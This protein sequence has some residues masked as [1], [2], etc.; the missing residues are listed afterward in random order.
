MPERARGV[1][2]GASA[3]TPF[4][5]RSA[6]GGT[7]ASCVRGGRE[8]ALCPGCGCAERHRL[9]WLWL[10]EEDRLIGRVLAFGPDDAS[11]ERLRRRPGLEYVSADV[12]ASQA[13]VVADIV[14]LPFA[15]A[16]FDAVLCS[17]VLEHVPGEQRALAELRRVVRPGGG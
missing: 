4:S 5:A 7:G 16:S 2:G 10:A 8:G 6:T 9:L 3:A 13:M 14:A 11:E 1:G 17:H 12:D 15:D